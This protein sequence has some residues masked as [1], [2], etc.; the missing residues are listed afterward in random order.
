M[1]KIPNIAMFLAAGLGMRLRPIT[2]HL[3]KPLV[4]VGGRPMIDYTL[5]RLQAAGVGKVVVNVHHLADML[6]D[7]LAQWTAL[8]PVIS[9]ETDWLMDS[10]SGVVKALTELGERPFLI[11]NG[12]SFWLEALGAIDTNLA[13]MGTAWDPH[14]MDM[15]VMMA[16]KH[17]AVGYDG[18]GDFLADEAG[19]LRRFDGRPPGPL[20][21]AGVIIAVPA[22]FDDAPDGLFS[23]NLC[24]D[25]AIAA[26]RLF[27]MPAQGLWLMVGTSEA[28][29]EA[30]AAMGTFRAVGAA[31][32]AVS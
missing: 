29:G 9:D 31:A 26:G 2:E 1:S 15:L 19:R 27:G 22:I 17:Q 30:E 21:Y 28:I 24:F 7:H 5:E 13:R 3:P 23:L 18:K 20:V 32:E 12:D 16:E 11:L 10:G 25:K 8:N 4:P 14:R 6:V